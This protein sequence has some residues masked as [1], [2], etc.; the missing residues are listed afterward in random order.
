MLMEAK[1]AQYWLGCIAQDSLK[2]LQLQSC[3]SLMQSKAAEELTILGIRSGVESLPLTLLHSCQS[4]FQP[5][6]ARVEAQVA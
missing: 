1:T 3:L 2:G 5:T 4:Y 6:E